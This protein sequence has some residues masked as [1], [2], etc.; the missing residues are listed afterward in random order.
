MF[1]CVYMHDNN[2][3]YMHADGLMMCGTPSLA[4]LRLSAPQARQGA[5][6][7]WVSCSPIFITYLR[8]PPHLFALEDWAS[9]IWRCVI[10]PNDDMRVCLLVNAYIHI[11]WMH[12][13]ILYMEANS[14]EW[15]RACLAPRGQADMAA[16]PTR[17][18]TIRWDAHVG[19]KV[20]AALATGLGL[21]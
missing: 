5:T 8:L 6:V 11:F 2:S 10:T 18:T 16:L 13:Y 19:D 4:V 14:C 3:M 21:L 15:R 17:C 1:A 20:R 9:A 12:A 7:V